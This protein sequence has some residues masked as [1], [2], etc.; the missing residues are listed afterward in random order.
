MNY[1]HVDTP[2]GTLQ[3]ISNGHELLRI[4]FEGHYN[5]DVIETNDAAL[6]NCAHQ[7]TEYFAGKRQYFKLPLAPDGTAFQ[8]SV[9]NAL[10]DIPYGESRSYKDIAQLIGNSDA[11]RAVGAANGRNPLPIVVPC[12]RVIGS[13]GSLTGFA[14]GLIT[15][16]FLLELEAGS[17]HATTAENL[18]NTPGGSFRH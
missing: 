2:I 6:V 14:G 5:S 15:K 18:L 3:L 10:A 13:N 16:T 7:L 12:H 17:K 9:W 11:V 1:N 4:A 8:R